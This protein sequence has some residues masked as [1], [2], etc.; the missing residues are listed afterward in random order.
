MIPTTENFAAKQEK[1]AKYKKR[2]NYENKIVNEERQLTFDF[3]KFS[4][5]CQQI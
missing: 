1:G 5:V 3:G 4:A 2:L